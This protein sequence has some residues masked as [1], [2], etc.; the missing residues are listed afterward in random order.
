MPNDFLYEAGDSVSVEIR[1]RFIENLN[2]PEGW[3]GNPPSIQFNAFSTMR[4]FNDENEPEFFC[5]CSDRQLE[6]SNYDFKLTPKEYGLDPCGVSDFSIGDLFEMRLAEGNFFPNEVR[7]LVQM[8]NYIVDPALPIDI[9][10]VQLA[11]L[12]LQGAGNLFENENL[13]FVKNG[14]A[15]EIDS[16]SYTHLTLPTILLV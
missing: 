10:E 14:N 5:R 12:N 13:T 15:F 1:I 9:R 7:P 3:T 2:L 16:V 6:L 4:L 11:S 8:T